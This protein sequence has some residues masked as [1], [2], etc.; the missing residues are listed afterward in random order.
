MRIGWIGLGAMGRSMAGHLV[1]AGH[2]LRVHTRTRA[3]AA[4]LENRGASWC[5]TPSEVAVGADVV[6]TMV[7][8]PSDVRD[9]VLGPT[10]AL[11]AMAPDTLFVDFTTSEPALAVEIAAAAAQGG[12]LALDAPVSGGDVGA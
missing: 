5:D 1:E 12:I 3:T 7:G 9:V 11:G 6:A 10:G 4:E 2:E 8:F